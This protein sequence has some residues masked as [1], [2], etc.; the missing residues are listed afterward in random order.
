MHPNN[1]K[2]AQADSAAKP[3][4]TWDSTAGKPI[5]PISEVG[6]SEEESMPGLLFGL[7]PPQPRAG[8]RFIPLRQKSVD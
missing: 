7:T 6:F 5:E 2:T 8:D 4:S 3:L 1:P